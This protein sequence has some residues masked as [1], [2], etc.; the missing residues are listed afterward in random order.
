MKFVLII[1]CFYIEKRMAVW[2]HALELLAR[3]FYFNINTFFTKTHIPSK[4]TPIPEGNSLNEENKE[5]SGMES[6]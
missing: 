2:I 5:L 4:H 6:F 3:Y 1:F